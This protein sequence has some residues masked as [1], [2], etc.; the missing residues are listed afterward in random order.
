MCQSSGTGIGLRVVT[1]YFKSERKDGS[2]SRPCGFY[3]R[4]RIILWRS[5]IERVKP[6]TGISRF[7]RR[8]VKGD[9]VAYN[10]ALLKIVQRPQEFYRYKSLANLCANK[11]RGSLQQLDGR[12]AEFTSVLV[13]LQA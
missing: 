4:G 6:E 9:I 7:R 11:R 2:G 8:V 1:I 3:L 12:L 10:A 13:R 5:F